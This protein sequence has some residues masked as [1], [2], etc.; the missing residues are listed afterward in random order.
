MILHVH[1]ITVGAIKAMFEKF[2]GV[3]V[4]NLP[5]QIYLHRWPNSLH[6]A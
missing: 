4:E 1:V 5:Q 6:C 2:Y 3:G